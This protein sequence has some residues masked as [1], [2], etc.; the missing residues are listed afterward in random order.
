MFKIVQRHYA[1][2][3]IRSSNQSTQDDP[4]VNRVFFGSLLF[5]YN[6]ISHLLYIHYVANGFMEHMMCIC[7]IFACII[8]IVGFAAIVFRKT[9]IF[10]I[11]DNIEKLINASKTVL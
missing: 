2:V 3:G 4:F 8:V 11:I 10:G 6:I 7:A 1:T 9:S 5:A